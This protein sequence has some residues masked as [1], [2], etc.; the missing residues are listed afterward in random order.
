MAQPELY[1]ISKITNGEVYMMPKPRALSL[2]EDIAFYRSQG[3]DAVVSLIRPQEVVEKGLSDERV[4]CEQ[5]GL[6]FFEFPIKDMDVPDKVEL[7][8]F[9]SQLKPLFDAGKNVTFHCQGGRGRAGTAVVSLMLMNGFNAEQ[10]I[11]I[12]SDGRGD[13][14]PVC[15][16]QREFLANFK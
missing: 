4:L 6:A 8:A 9:L 14:V 3:I 7:E 5:A 11:K 15:D 12:A 2:K 1:F 13:Q 16:I 10:A